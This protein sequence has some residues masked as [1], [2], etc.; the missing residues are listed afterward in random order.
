MVVEMARESILGLMA[1]FM[2][3][4]LSM[5]LSKDM[6]I[7]LG[8]MEITMKESLSIICNGHQYEREFFNDQINGQGKYTWTDCRVYVGSFINFKAQR[9]GIFTTAEGEFFN[10][11]FQGQGKSWSNGEVYEGQYIDVVKQGHGTLTTAAGDQYEGDFFNDVGK[12]VSTYAEG[13]IYDEE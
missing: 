10:N 12:G 11:K 13:N 7:S 1:E 3:D 4:S 9:H 6:V 2:Q 5:V 8:L